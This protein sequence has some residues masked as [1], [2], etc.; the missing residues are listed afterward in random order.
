[1]LRTLWFLA[2]LLVFT[3]IYGLTAIIAGLLRLPNKPGG[4]YDHCT[5]DWSRA[6]LW[7]AGTKVRT[8]G[9]DRLPKGGVVYASNHQSWFDIFALATTVPGQM[10]FVSKIELSRIPVQLD[11]RDEPH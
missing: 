1:M 9:L 5:S 6:L 3:L 4:V 7:A 11:L 10:R 8:S 2:N